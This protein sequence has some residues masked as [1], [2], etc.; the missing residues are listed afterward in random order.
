MA[1]ADTTTNTIAFLIQLLIIYPD[2]Q[3]KVQNELDLICNENQLPQ[4]KDR[5]RYCI[6]FFK[7]IYPLFISHQIKNTMYII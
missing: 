5:T 7:L 2:I 6:F 4:L 1:G 3:I